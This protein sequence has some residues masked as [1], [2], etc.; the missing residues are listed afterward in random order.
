MS[1][2]S[3][4]QALKLL[5]KQLNRCYYCGEDLRFGVP[6]EQDHIICRAVCGHDRVYNMCIA[7]K[8]CN[9]KKADKTLDEF[10]EYM[11]RKQPNRLIR[12]QFYFEFI[13]LTRFLDGK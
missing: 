13:G 8:D 4:G 6:Y 7:C 1:A 2:L 3:K 11:I 12:G 10:K 5:K 9:R